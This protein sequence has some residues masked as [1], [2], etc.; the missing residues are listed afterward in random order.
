MADAIRRQLPPD[1]AKAAKIL[2][3]SLGKPLEGVAGIFTKGYWLMPVTRFVEEFGLADYDLSMEL[4]A[5]ITRRYTWEYA[6]HS[7]FPL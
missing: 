2:S 6:V 4:C 5:Q 1:H 7:L 3:K